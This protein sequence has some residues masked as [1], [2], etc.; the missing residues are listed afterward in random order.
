MNTRSLLL[1]ICTIWTAATWAGPITLQQAQ[2]TAVDFVQKQFA[3]GKT[4]RRADTQKSVE[5]TSASTAYY[6]FNIGNNEGFVLVSGDDRTVPILGYS[7]KGSFD[8]SSMPDNMRSFLAEYEEAISNL[9]TNETY[10]QQTNTDRRASRTDIEPIVDVHYNQNAPYCMDTPVLTYGGHA[11][12][13][14]TGCVATAMAQVMKHYEYP[15]KTSSQIPSYQFTFQNKTYTVNA[16]EADSVIHWENILNK[17]EEEYTGTDQEQAVAA[18]MSICGTAI[19]MNYGVNE[20][21][22]SIG[23]VNLMPDALTAYFDYKA[24]VKFIERKSYS[25]DSWTDVIYQELKAGRPVIYSGQSANSGHTF[26]CDGYKKEDG[27]DLFHINWGWG[28]NADGYFT[29]AMR[30]DNLGLGGGTD[31]S[32]YGMAQNAIIGIAPND[33]T[34]VTQPDVLSTEFI[35][36]KDY[37]TSLTRGSVSEPFTGMRIIYRVWSENAETHN[38]DLGLRIIDSEGK[39]IQDI[40]DTNAQSYRMARWDAYYTGTK[41]GIDY[42]VPIEISA[43]LP[44]GNY[45]IIA[46]SRVTGSGDM[47]PNNYSDARHIAFTIYNNTLTVTEMFKEPVFNLQIDG[48]ITITP[49]D[50]KMVGRPHQVSFKL[51]NLGTDFHDDLYYTLNNTEPNKAVYYATHVELAEG[52]T[53]IASHTFYFKPNQAGTNTIYIYARDTYNSWVQ[54]GSQTINGISAAPEISL[55]TTEVKEYDTEAD[56][57][58]GNKLTVKLKLTNSG[59]VAT[60]GLTYFIYLQYSK[61]DGMTWEDLDPAYPDMFS[62]L[63]MWALSL[64]PGQSEEKEFTWEGLNYDYI[65]RV[66]FVNLLDANDYLYTASYRL[67]APPDVGVSA[68][69]AADNSKNDRIYNLNGQCV[70]RARQQ[71]Q[72]GIYLQNGKKFMIK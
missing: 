56:A 15:Q 7:N 65:H 48:D 27:Q 3:N 63:Q 1:A 13:A 54:I 66:Y 37:V 22:G 55:E 46:T 64:A 61:E 31:T 72:R 35:N 47:Q 58:V 42:S 40:S 69:I 53:S 59:A 62:G 32:G 30:P 33:G 10:F 68:I 60:N 4:L 9:Q 25:A 28:E 26:I 17:Y 2:E 34:P 5:Q 19:K 14:V 49:V 44:D 36:P 52:N 50:N 24:T 39:T 57:I 12:H 20:T 6:A 21:G 67:V 51:K 16:I 8:L 38:Y 43:S 70:G 45:R 11:Q 29:L 23:F 71:L 41:A 18:L